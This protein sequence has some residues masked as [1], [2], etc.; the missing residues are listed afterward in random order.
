MEKVFTIKH[1]ISGNITDVTPEKWESMKGMNRNWEKIGESR[2]LL[3]TG[4]VEDQNHEDGKLKRKAKGKGEI[5]KA[6]NPHPWATLPTDESKK[7]EGI[8][9]FVMP[10]PPEQE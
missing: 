5:I 3:G 1:R 9:D 2:V 7:V 8:L 4:A 10:G 6:Q